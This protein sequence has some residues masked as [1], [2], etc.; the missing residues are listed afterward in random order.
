MLSLEGGRDMTKR[1][2]LLGTSPVW[3]EEICHIGNRQLV[4]VSGSGGGTGGGPATLP[5]V[6]T[7]YRFHE[8]WF[9]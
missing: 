7:N 8:L 4:C 9:Q 5:L 2:G 3:A 6:P 1:C